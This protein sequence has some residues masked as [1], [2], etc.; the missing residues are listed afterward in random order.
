MSAVP[1]PGWAFLT[2]H[3]PMLVCL[4]RN[5]T[6]SLRAVAQQT[7]ITPR[8]VRALATVREGGAQHTR[9]REGPRHRDK[10]NRAY[11]RRH[12]LESHRKS[13]GLLDLVHRP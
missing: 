13:C 5:E 9:T 12:P 7:G 11:R 4:D 2:N 6:T 3:T 10:F 8:T 1:A